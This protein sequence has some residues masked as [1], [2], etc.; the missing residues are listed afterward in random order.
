MFNVFINDIFYSITDSSFYNYA[1]NN[2]L[3][4]AHPACTVLNSVL[5]RDS[6]KLIGWFSFSYMKANPDKFQAISQG[7]KANDTIM[8]F[9]FRNCM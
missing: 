2:T 1:D 4:F 9:K 5:K 8:S 3:S 7:K 6:E